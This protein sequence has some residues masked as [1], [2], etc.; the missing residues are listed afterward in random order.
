MYGCCFSPDGSMVLSCSDDK[1]LKL[2]DTKKHSE[3]KMI[4]EE[5]RK[6][7]EQKTNK[8]MFVYYWC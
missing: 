1:T 5:K 6:F 4:E 3:E 7:E 2:W 8:P